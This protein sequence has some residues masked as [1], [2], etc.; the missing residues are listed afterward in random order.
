MISEKALRFPLSPLKS[1]Y[2][3]LPRLDSRLMAALPYIRGGV[4][5]DI[6]TDH[7]YLPVVLL[8]LNQCRFAVA[9]DIHRGPAGIAARNLER[10][11]IGDDRAAVLLT[12]GLHGVEEYAPDDII[13]FGMGGEMIARILDEGATWI[14]TSAVR[15]ILQPMTHPEILRNYLDDNGYVIRNQ[16]L[17]RADRIYQVICAEYDGSPRSHSLLEQYIGTHNLTGGDALCLELVEHLR[18]VISTR[19]EK[20]QQ[21]GRVTPE[22]DRLLSEIRQYLLSKERTS[23]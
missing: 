22:E 3:P 11:G 10:Y 14:K 19:R 23:L 20:K 18:Q 7:A 9:S 16:R 4:V 13:L 5:A 6:G 12:D 2:P 17:V 1:P 8:S 21:S 15:L